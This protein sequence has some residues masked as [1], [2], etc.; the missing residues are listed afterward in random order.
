MEQQVKRRR[1]AKWML[2]FL[3]VVA[4]G[5]VGYYWYWYQTSHVKYDHVTNAKRV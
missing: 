3:V 5:S 4:L 1:R 2:A